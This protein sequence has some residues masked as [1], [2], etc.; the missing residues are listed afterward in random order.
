MNAAIS[1]LQQQL[2]LLTKE[3]KQLEENFDAVPES[4]LMASIISELSTIANK[5]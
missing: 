1:D 4:I 2:D 3:Q 5:I